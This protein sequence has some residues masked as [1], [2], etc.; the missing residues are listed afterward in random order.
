MSTL[1]TVGRLGAPYGVK[2]WLKLQS[3][4]QPADNIVSYQ[5]WYLKTRTGVAPMAVAE[6]KPHAD[7]LVVKIEGVDDREAA[8]AL[9]HGEIQVDAGQL[10]DLEAGDY[11]WHQLE[12]LKVISCYNGAE[13]VLGVV[14]RLVETGA[15]DVL[16][17]KASKDSIDKRERWLP[18]QPGEVV[19][20]VDLAAATLLVDWDPE[21]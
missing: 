5:P 7:G 19:K 13:L 8:S 9:T 1:I 16:V 17:V 15:N 2:G 18:Y 11:Y 14:N 10:P 4:T 21:F 12:G 20:A 3:F 6:L